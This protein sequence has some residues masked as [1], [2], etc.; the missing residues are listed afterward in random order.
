MAHRSFIPTMIV[1]RIQIYHRSAGHNNRTDAWNDMHQVESQI[2]ADSGH[3]DQLH[4]QSGRSRN[5]VLND[6]SK[7][8]M[9]PGYVIQYEI[10]QPR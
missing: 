4:L 3:P 6:A 1:G 5:H 9:I 2:H 8:K 7:T 10:R